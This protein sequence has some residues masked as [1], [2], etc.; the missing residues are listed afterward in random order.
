[1]LRGCEDASQNVPQALSKYRS[2]PQGAAASWK[3]PSEEG[4]ARVNC[5]GAS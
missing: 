1:M 3:P 2:D 5:S 4:P